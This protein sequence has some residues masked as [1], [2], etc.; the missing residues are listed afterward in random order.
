[1][2]RWCRPGAAVGGLTGRAIRTQ[3]PP[4]PVATVICHLDQYGNVCRNGDETDVALIRTRQNEFFLQ[5]VFP[6]ES[7]VRFP[8]PGLA[9]I[10]N[11]ANMEYFNLG[12]INLYGG[13][14]LPD[15]VRSHRFNVQ[16]DASDQFHDALRTMQTVRT[17]E[18]LTR[19]DRRANFRD[20]VAHWRESPNQFMHKVVL[21]LL[22]A[23]VAIPWLCF[24]YL[25]SSVGP[26]GAPLYWND[27]VQ[28]A[29][30]DTLLRG[31]P[32]TGPVRTPEDY[33]VDMTPGMADFLDKR[34][35]AELLDEETTAVT[36]DPLVTMYWQAEHLQA[37]G[38]W[39][40]PLSDLR[41][42]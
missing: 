22:L 4:R 31:V 36:E 21:P 28:N 6:D 12:D 27:R 23:C 7:V 17:T 34:Q 16:S 35:T 26:D 24:R 39:P 41:D 14:L 13:V 29:A 25:S 2:R 19:K 33:P 9:I 30:I 18:K 11:Q 37:H 5:R 3:V 10:K 20:E 8:V 42:S 1:M 38:H 32:E 15:E 40:R